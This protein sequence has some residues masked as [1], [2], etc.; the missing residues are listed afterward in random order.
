[1]LQ[2]DT[3]LGTHCTGPK[4]VPHTAHEAEESGCGALWVPATRHDP[5]LPVVLAA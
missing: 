5:F 3:G 1:M 2:P 4:D